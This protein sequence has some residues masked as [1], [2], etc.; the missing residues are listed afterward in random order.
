MRELSMWLM[1]KS[2]KVTF[3]NSNMKDDRVSLPKTK[4]ALEKMNADEDDVYMTSIHDR[5]AARPNILEDL[6]LA[7]FAVNYE[8]LTR[9]NKEGGEEKNIYD[10]KSW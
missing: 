6:C 4:A 8:V 1:K 3:V 9:G 10:D 2:R 5:Y 7:K